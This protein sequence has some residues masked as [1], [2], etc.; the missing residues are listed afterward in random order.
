MPA[1]IV[2]RAC[3]AKSRLPEQFTGRKVRCPKC[4]GV[5]S[6]DDGSS[7]APRPA[8]RTVPSE[9]DEEIR[10]V[11]RREP[12]SPRPPESEE[13]DFPADD[14]D[15]RVKK[16][17]KRKKRRARQDDEGSVGTWIWWYVA[18]ACVVLALGVAGFLVARAG[19]VE[20]V[21]VAGI[22]LA[23]MVP[24]SMVILVIS[25]LLSSTIAG[26]INFG[27]IHTA[28]PKAA[29]LIIAVNLVSLIPFGGFL[30]FPIWVVGAMYAFDLD[31]WEAR[32]LIFVNWALNFGFK[33]ILFHALLAMMMHGGKGD[34]DDLAPSPRRSAPA[35]PQEKAVE[36]IE[37]LGGSCDDDEEVEEMRIIG[38]DL[39]DTQTGNA[40]LVHLKDFPALRR[41]NLSNTRVTDAGLAH[42]KGLKQLQL[43]NLRGTKVT[44]DGVRELQ[45][46]LPAAKILTGAAPPPSRRGRP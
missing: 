15:V 16:E 11:K 25:M 44:P 4:A 26:G 35:S 5:I 10:V 18:V 28:I 7:P 46:A 42:L 37:K 22:E 43:V 24:V 31:F 6:L 27:E 21:I 20:W 3:G 23:V 38:V 36:A 41:L 12:L 1:I 29:L 45:K 39:A 2:C 30:T 9:A 32:F 40:D 13:V 33:L 34:L 14:E 8:P 19:H 17:K